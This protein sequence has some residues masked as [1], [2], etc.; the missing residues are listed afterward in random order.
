VLNRCQLDHPRR[1]RG[2]HIPSKGPQ[3]LAHKN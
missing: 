1:I 3:L 2:L